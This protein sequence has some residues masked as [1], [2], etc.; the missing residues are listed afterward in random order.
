MSHEFCFIITRHVISN[1][2]NKYWIECCAQI[3]K[4]YKEPI[5][6]IDD[7]S[8]MRL[9]SKCEI[10]DCFIIKSEFPKRGEILPFYY[11]CKYKWAPKAVII[12][13]SSFIQQYIPFSQMN[14]PG[15]FFWHF[16]PYYDNRPL[17]E[18][19]IKRIK[20]KEVMDL[21]KSDHW[22]GCFGCQCVIQLDFL[23]KVEAK[24]NL[25]SLLDYICHRDHRMAFE[26]VLALSCQLEFNGILSSPSL[27]GSIFRQNF[28]WKQP[29]EYYIDFIK[30]SNKILCPLIKT[31]TGR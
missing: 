12:H 31:W 15:Y 20:N 5:Y 9:T 21:F 18:I 14:D 10:P 2:T 30:P 26:R 17:I 22:Y 6:I 25:F 11:L 1:K 27:Y 7:N 19:M 4:F 13:D 28:R 8:N 29:F 16:T 3:R 23:E 24:Y